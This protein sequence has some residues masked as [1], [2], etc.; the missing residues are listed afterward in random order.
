[1]D[2]ITDISIE[3]KKRIFDFEFSICT[4]V[5]RKDEYAEM[6][7]SFL[8]KGFEK[9][10]CE[11]LFID[12]SE[13][14]VFNGYE[15]VNLFLRQARGKYIII[16]HQDILIQ[17]DDITKLRQCLKEL[18]NCNQS[19]ALCGNAGAAGPNH[20][21][22][23]ITYPGN[24]FNSK[25]KFPLKVS[26]LD[27]NFVLV[28]NS[29][30]L[31]VSDNLTGFHLYATDLCLQAELNGYSAYVINF[32][33]LHK[34]KGNRNADFYIT[35]TKLIKKYNYFFRGRWVQTNSTVFYISGS[36]FRKLYGNFITRF[37][38]KMANGIKKRV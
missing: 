7:Q 5:T 36:F 31:K 30:C 18:D 3:I 25:G 4:I 19:W 2:D 22:Y 26:S 17:Q 23:N 32:N 6:L 27:E 16:C 29:A 15:G 35:R 1:M 12:N 34:S 10:F 14:N 33:L 13:K 9:S 20:I 38:I 11:Y 21:V 28:K 8:I 37:F 24:E